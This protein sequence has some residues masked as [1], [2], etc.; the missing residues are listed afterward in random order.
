MPCRDLSPQ[1][2]AARLQWLRAHYVPEDERGARVR[3]EDPAGR[4]P[5]GTFA[6]EVEHRL[7]ELRALCELTEYLQGARPGPDPR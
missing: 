6:Q 2:V 1:A 5:C 7:A 4:R 3:L